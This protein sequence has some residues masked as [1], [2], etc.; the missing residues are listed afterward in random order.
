LIEYLVIISSCYSVKQVCEIFGISRQAYYQQQQ[1]VIREKYQEEIV[2]QFVYGIRKRQTKIGGRKLYERL[3]SEFIAIGFRLGR[4]RFFMILRENNLLIQRKKKY[5]TTTN[6]SHRF[7]VYTN[8]IKG[9]VVK[10]PGEVIVGDITYIDTEEGFMY[11]AL[12]T[13]IYCRKI[14]GY[15]I[16][17]SLSVEGSIRSLQMAIETLKAIGEMK[18]TI[19]HSDRGVQYCC[20]QY[21]KILKINKVRIS[22]A[23]KGNPYENAIAER[24]NGILKIEF[25]LDQKFSTKQEAKYSTKEAIKIYNEE[26]PHMSLDYL[27][28]EEKFEKYQR[29]RL[30]KIF[31]ENELTPVGLRPP[32][33]SSFSIRS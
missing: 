26:R 8:L 1:R 14:I 24:V 4:D 10:S 32:S 15:D 13:D 17:E 25:L 30:K 12:L 22:M 19:H 6:S 3:K 33:V 21:V 29:E 31:I 27:T 23:E 28:P 18:E 11:L 20:Y 7:R 9:L 5:I 16:S 2:L